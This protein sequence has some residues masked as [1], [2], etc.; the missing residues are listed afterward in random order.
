VTDLALPLVAARSIQVSLAGAA[1]IE[2]ENS[3]SPGGVVNI[4]RERSNPTFLPPRS[5]GDKEEDAPSAAV[6]EP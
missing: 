6:P 1:I 3:F 4:S 2:I 5:I